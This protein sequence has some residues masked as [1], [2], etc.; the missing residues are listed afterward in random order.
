MTNTTPIPAEIHAI[1]FN[2]FIILKFKLVLLTDTHIKFQQNITIRQIRRYNKGQITTMKQR[3]T[4]IDDYEDRGEEYASK[5]K[6]A[7]NSNKGIVSYIVKKC[8][9]NKTGF[10]G[11]F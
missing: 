9:L 10:T 5:I 11:Y 1:Q 6:R 2:A 3:Q 8:L 4:V 7:K